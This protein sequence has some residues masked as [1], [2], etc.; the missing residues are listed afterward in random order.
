MRLFSTNHKSAPVSFKKAVLNGLAG[1]GGLFMPETL[2]EMSG[3]FLDGLYGRTL[4]EIACDVFRTLLRDEFP[5]G[6]LQKIVEEVFTFDAPLV[7]L[8][9]RLHV[10]EL[11]HGP[12]LAFK[13]FGART[14]AAIMARYAGQSTGD[15]SI[16][17]ATSGDTGA[18]VGQ[19]FSGAEGIRV[20]VLYP[21][22]KVSE[23]QEKQFTT[24]G[25]NITALE[26]EGNFDDCQR[27]VK[28]AFADPELSR[29][30][31]LTT[32][33][34]INIARLLPQMIYYMYAVAQLDRGHKPV[35]FSVPSGNFGNLTA[36]LMAFK[37]GLPVRRFIAATNQ[38][39]SVPRY[40]AGEN[41]V[42]VP[43]LESI[44]NAMDVG[45]PSNFARM[46][47]LFEGQKTSLQAVVSGAYYSDE[48]TRSA[49]REA[50]DRFGYTFDPHGAVAFAGYRDWRE[51]GSLQSEGIVLATAHPAKFP[52]T[53]EQVT[54]H[55]I[56][57][58]E[59]LSGLSQKKK[60]AVP[61]KN[62]YEA[63]RACLS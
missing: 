59:Q 32:A 54:G 30:L 56:P 57:V 13:D 51:G 46:L 7:K 31:N 20:Y 3:D 39:N 9:D 2:P 55:D 44:S 34:S 35:V 38:N 25:G 17:T 6:E 4:A 29:R 48:E 8:N 10:L 53:V 27:M 61:L 40:L 11:F 41:F 60:L 62:N 42:A 63:L 49:I 5:E 47:E 22:G 16:L 23:L 18:A 37:M 24:L 15:I 52:A 58:P 14:M 26:V 43:S 1:D 36:G 19:G 50:Y 33:N 45:N 21:K 28:A 12:T